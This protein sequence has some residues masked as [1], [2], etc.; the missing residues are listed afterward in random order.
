MSYVYPYLQAEG[1]CVCVCVCVCV[2]GCV[3]ACV[4]VCVQQLVLGY[5]CL[6]SLSLRALQLILGQ[7]SFK[8]NIQSFHF[9]LGA[10]KTGGVYLTH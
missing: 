3:C 5:I 8:V 4:C 9:S 6:N 1:S 2:C 7:E 10:I